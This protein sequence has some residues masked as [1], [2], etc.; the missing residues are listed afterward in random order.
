MKIEVEL[1]ITVYIV[2]LEQSGYQS[3][4]Q[5]VIGQSVLISEFLM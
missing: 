2:M 5:P 4:G 1:P 3:P